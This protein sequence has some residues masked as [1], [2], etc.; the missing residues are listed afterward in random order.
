MLYSTQRNKLYIFSDDYA[1]ISVFDILTGTI[2]SELNLGKTAY[3]NLL[4][5]PSRCSFFSSDNDSIY[6]FNVDSNDIDQVWTYSMETN[7]IQTKEI[8]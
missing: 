6:F 7:Q 2:T 1:K 8:Y 5:D 4:M 3:P